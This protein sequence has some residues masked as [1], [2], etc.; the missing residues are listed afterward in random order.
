VPLRF[1]LALALATA[2]LLCLPA[3]S[4]RTLTTIP[5][6]QL[7]VIKVLLAQEEA[8]NR[9]DL[10]AFAQA[11]KDAPDTLF[12]TTSVNRGFAGM[13]EAYKRNYP[14]KAAMG[15]LAFSELEVRPLDERFAVLIGRYHLERGKKDGG[16]TEG[17]FSLV[18]EK[19]EKGWK[20][21]VDH[22]TG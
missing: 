18:L 14:T 22:T 21:V 9:G 2:T 4:Q 15:E 13:V 8:W 19:T 5:Q 11:Y 6:Q 7:D 20:I 3:Q 10:E 12:I 17:L 1:R 16:N